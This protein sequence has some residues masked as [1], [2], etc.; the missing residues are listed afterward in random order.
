MICS[1]T[2]SPFM[3]KA[4]SVRLNNY[5]FRFAFGGCTTFAVRQRQ[6][7]PH[8]TVKQLWPLVSA[9]RH[10]LS[11]GMI[12]SLKIAISVSR[13]A[14]GRFIQPTS[15]M[16]ASNSISARCQPSDG[17][18]WYIN[19]AFRIGHVPFKRSRADD[20]ICHGAEMQTG[21]SAICLMTTPKGGAC[22]R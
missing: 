3:K 10:S 22:S 17:C 18:G 1:D 2:S 15:A 13:Q 5:L 8:H 21:L 6:R 20:L 16:I 4:S 19:G 12:V 14:S 7:L 9:W 11:Q